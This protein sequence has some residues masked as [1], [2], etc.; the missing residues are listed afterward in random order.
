M[1]IEILREIGSR[2]MAGVKGVQ[3]DNRAISRGAGGDKTYPVDKL[4]EEIIIKALEDSGEPLTVISEEA[5][6]V[7]LKGGGDIVLIDPIDGSNNAVT[8]IPFY[9]TSIAVAGGG[10][11]GDVKLSYIINLVNGDEYWAI[12]GAG[13]WKNGQVI[14]GQKD[15]V[16]YL[17][18]Y[19]ASSPGRDIAAILPLLS[20]SR[21]TRCWG[22]TALSL[23]CVASGAASVLVIPSPSRSFDFAGGWLIVKEAGGIVTDIRGNDIDNVELG[24]KRAST[25]L[26]SGNEALHRKVLGLL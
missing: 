22:A 23:A 12:K 25:V 9:C 20:Q 18:S 14:A 5:G 1:K 11:L 24:L 10:R 19:E 26:A 21:R 13:A 2:L 8:G 6:I 4:A 17:T 15:D 16:L 7:D 3:P